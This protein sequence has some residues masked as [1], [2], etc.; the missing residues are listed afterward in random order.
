MKQF[1]I[2]KG[3]DEES[4]G[5]DKEIYGGPYIKKT[6]ELGKF[7]IIKEESSSA[8]VHRV[9]VFSNN[10]MLV[11]LLGFFLGGI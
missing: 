4:D 9:K 8:G 10:Y 3:K 6:S 11:K 7:K 1:D 5:N 2:K